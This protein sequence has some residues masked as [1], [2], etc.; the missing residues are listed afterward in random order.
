LSRRLWRLAAH[1]FQALDEVFARKFR[2]AR[3]LDL[4]NIVRYG[5]ASYSRITLELRESSWP[6]ISCLRVRRCEILYDSNSIKNGRGQRLILE[7]LEGPPT[8]G[9][10]VVKYPTIDAAKGWCSS[11]VHQ[12]VARHRFLG[13]DYRV[14]VVEGP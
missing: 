6:P 5:V 10:V 7:T 8:E 3:V 2:I 13:A 11:P 9:A 1:G 14:F 4:S 12:D